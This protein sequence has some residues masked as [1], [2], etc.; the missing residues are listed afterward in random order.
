MPG[1]PPEFKG[2]LERHENH[3][4]VKD[5]ADDSEGNEEIAQ[6]AFRSQIGPAKL[7][8]GDRGRTQ[9]RAPRMRDAIPDSVMHTIDMSAGSGFLAERIG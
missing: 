5:A 4:R 9:P 1:Q 2:C 8:R 6:V 3:R 7:T